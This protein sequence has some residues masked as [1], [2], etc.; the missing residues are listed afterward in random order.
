MM[1]IAAGTTRVVLL[2]GSIAIKIGRPRVLRLVLRLL[3][4]SLT[5]KQ[6]H[7]L[8]VKYG[9]TFGEICCNY[10]LAGL[11]ANRNEFKY[12]QLFQDVRVMPTTAQ[13]L[14]G[15]IILQIRG[16][17]ITSTELASDNP[18]LGFDVGQARAE[19]SDAHQF[20]RHPDGH[21][22]LVDYARLPPPKTIVE[23]PL[24]A[25]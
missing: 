3:F 15:W 20:C 13:Y 22:V 8:F 2:I 17:N 11:I 7:R 10:A 19:I 1:Q 24:S 18:F 14:G 6:R 4:G 21:I 23:S 5:Q 25:A 12:Y 16:S 9:S